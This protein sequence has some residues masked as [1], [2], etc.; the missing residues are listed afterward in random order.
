MGCYKPV[1]VSRACKMVL[2]RIFL[3]F[4][5]VEADGPNPSMEIPALAWKVCC[6]KNG[7]RRVLVDT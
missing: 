5:A 7:C 4:V 2:L 6:E 1:V 3:D